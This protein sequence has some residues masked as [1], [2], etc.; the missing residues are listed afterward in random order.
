MN[1]D[2]LAEENLAQ[3]LEANKTLAKTVVV[4]TVVNIDGGYAVIDVGYKAAGKVNLKEFAGIELNIGDNVEVFVVACDSSDDSGP[5]ISR[6]RAVLENSWAELEKYHS[7]NRPVEGQIT[8][9]NKNGYIVDIGGVSTL[10]QIQRNIRKNNQYNVGFTHAFNIV[11][12]DRK[13]NQVFV[14]L[15]TQNS[16][17]TPETLES[18]GIVEGAIVVGSIKAITS[19]GIFVNVGGVDCLLHNSEISWRKIDIAKT[20]TVGQEIT[21][22]VL[23]VQ[24]DTGR[25]SLGRKQIE[26]DLWVE[27][28]N[29]IVVGTKY[30]LQITHILRHGLFVEISNGIEGFVY[31]SNVSWRRIGDLTSIFTVGQSID[32]IALGIDQERR[33][34]SF[35][36]K[37]LYPNPFYS[38][39]ETHSVGD[40]VD[41]TVAESLEIGILVHITESVDGLIRAQ[42]LPRDAVGVD[43]KKFKV[44]EAL[45]VQI[46]S[47]DTNR[48]KISLGL[49]GGEYTSSFDRSLYAKVMECTVVSSAHDGIVVNTANHG[50]GFVRR[51]DIGNAESVGGYSK[52][53][54]A[55]VIK[56]MVNGYDERNNRLL[57]SIK[58]YEIEGERKMIRQYSDNK[59][60]NIDFGEQ[61]TSLFEKQDK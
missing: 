4:G 43:Q 17:I 6:E 57:L 2:D 13:S 29:S 41:C 61:L 32:V 27:I 48:C 1:R 12:V 11:K 49:K 45:K 9:K 40:E 8:G 37:Q 30:S 58:M 53:A 18:A 60:A 47:I 21:V 20:F 14:E 23:R 24:P 34:I 39:A 35:G 38:F 26:Q 59:N 42:D 15:V 33:H 7:D 44:G 5:I 46:L 31:I 51:R 54:P 28:A 3:M 22:K 19:Y 36:I 25:V 52:F 16:S 56:A 50:A 55:D 10:W